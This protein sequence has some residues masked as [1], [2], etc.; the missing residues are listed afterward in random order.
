[1]IILITSFVFVPRTG[2][3]ENST[4]MLADELARIGHQVTVVTKT[5]TNIEN[6]YDFDVV[7]NPSFLTLLKLSLKADIL[8]QNHP[9]LSLGLPGLFV[10]AATVTLHQTWLSDGSRRAEIMSPIKRLFVSR[11]RNLVNS[12]ALGKKLG[13]QYQVLGNPYE[14]RIFYRR[15]VAKEKNAWIVVGRLIHDKGMDIAIRALAEFSKTNQAV[16]LDIIGEGIEREKLA[17]LAEELG[18]QEKVNFLGA[19]RGEELAKEYSKHSIAIVPSR[20]EEP[21]GIVALEGLACGCRLVCARSGGLPEAA[22]KVA[23]FFEKN[24]VEGCLGAIR[25]AMALGDYSNEEWKLIEEH[26]KPYRKENYIQSLCSIFNQVK[27]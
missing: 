13:M 26:L 14:S 6:S 10:R 16:T 9:S 18:V 3:I 15:E 25:E 20:W 27:K 22:G 19:L 24:S 23:N 5:M 17:Q 1:M 4:L 21:F 2:G 12:E 7:R 11:S 8:F